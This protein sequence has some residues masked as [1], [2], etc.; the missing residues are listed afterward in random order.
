MLKN[1][2][3][4]GAAAAL[5]V[6]LSLSTPANA[7]DPG[8]QPAQMQMLLTSMRMHHD[9]TRDGGGGEA[10]RMREIMDNQ[11]KCNSMMKQFDASKTPNAKAIA[12]GK[13][14]ELHCGGVSPAA[15]ERGV[16]EM[17]SALSM[18]GMKPVYDW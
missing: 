9:R 11:D 4:L 6:P 5:L 1:V 10:E 16:G 2:L 3:S 18:I 7:K 13:K 14:A 17:K 15:T 12:L 8:I